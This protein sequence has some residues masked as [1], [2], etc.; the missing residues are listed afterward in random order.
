MHPPPGP[1]PWEFLCPEWG[2]FLAQ[3]SGS[4]S[5]PSVGGSTPSSSAWIRG[6]S[7]VPP[8]WGS[9]MHSPSL[10]ASQPTAPLVGIREEG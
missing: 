6:A 9:L 10:K 4:C 8:L 1:D 3:G 7:L 5:S 2:Q